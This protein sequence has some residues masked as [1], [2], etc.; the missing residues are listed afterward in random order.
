LAL[1]SQCYAATYHLPPNTTIRNGQKVHFGD[2]WISTTG[3]DIHIMVWFVDDWMNYTVDSSGSQ[4]ICN[5]SKPTSVFLDGVN[6]TE[7]DGWSYYG[8]TITAV[9]GATSNVAIY[10]GSGA[11]PS[12]VSVTVTSPSNTTYT[13]ETIPV[14]ISATGGTIDKIWWNCKNG[15]SWIYGSNQTYTTPTS[16]TGFVN[17]TSYT[18]YGW[19]NNTD[20]NMDEQ[21]VW[22]TVQI[23]ITP[24]T[25]HY[26]FYFSCYDL[27]SNSVSDSLVSYSLFNASQL[28]T[29][30]EGQTTL[31]AGTY[32]LK[33]YF[34]GSAIN[35]TSLATA[36]FGNTTIN[37]YLQFK[38]YAL[39]YLGFSNTVTGLLLHNESTYNLTFTLY[40]SVPMTL[41]LEF[42]NKPSYVLKDGVI[43]TGW[44][45]VV[46]GGYVTLTATSLSV[47]SLLYGVEEPPVTPPVYGNLFNLYFPATSSLAFQHL[48][49]TYQS[50][51][52]I[53]VV[54]VDSGTW[55]GTNCQLNMYVSGGSLYFE[56]LDS[57]TLSFSNVSQFI[58]K[59]N[60]EP[61]T[62]VPVN[63][64]GGQPYT[65]EWYLTSVVWLLPYMFIL[66]MVG[67]SASF[68]GPMYAIYKVKHGEYYEGMRLGVIITALGFALVIAWLWA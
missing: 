5:G 43:Q 9:T 47:W 13:N 17:G 54:T 32:T 68:A 27:D 50:V 57:A 48:P 28:L 66:G 11:G 15:S 67:L 8:G 24:P 44:T 63:I 36:T 7:G 22:F 61:Y 51:G 56:S 53:A 34:H 19:A 26:Y 2:Y 30:A 65:I 23:I 12:E 41:V 59:V 6:K 18:F 25:D 60:G 58:F 45:Y 49:V 3:T 38:H 20:G 1:L 4:Q 37:L 29:Y 39:G 14:Q 62:G 64:L 52:G 16:M 31:V 33:T 35:Q 55:N 10:W 40:G 42:P 21:I 46:G